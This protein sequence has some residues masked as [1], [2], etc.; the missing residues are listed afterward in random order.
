MATLDIRWIDDNSPNFQT[1]IKKATSTDGAVTWTDLGIIYDTGVAV[2]AGFTLGQPILDVEVGVPKQ[3]GYVIELATSGSSNPQYVYITGDTSPTPIAVDTTNKPTPPSAFGTQR[4]FWVD[5]SGNLWVVGLSPVTHNIVT[6]KSTDN[7][8]TWTLMDATHAPTV[9]NTGNW[10]WDV[11]N[12][13]KIQF[14]VAD[15]S[16]F[17]ALQEFD[18]ATGLYTSAHDS[19]TAL[20]TGWS[21][22]QVAVN[23]SVVAVQY[24]A[25]ASPF[26][27]SLAIFDVSWNNVGIISNDTFLCTMEIDSTGTSYSVHGHIDGSG[28]PVMTVSVYSVAGS[29]IGDAA[30]PTGSADG[31]LTGSP[32][33]AVQQPYVDAPNGNV[34]FP[35]K[36]FTTGGELNGATF[37]CPIGGASLS[38]PHPV[39]ATTLAEFYGGQVGSP[40]GVTATCRVPARVP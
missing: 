1:V 19:N 31:D 2:P 24:A 38:S 15:G 25:A 22:G 21:L 10:Y 37:L 13:T 30:F 28:N 7:G 32:T 26:K 14:I 23:Q 8:V 33:G 4:N 35:T 11:V 12:S 9:A 17:M 20:G 40:G 36:C 34:V 29:H 18:T 6:Y 39:Q 27:A 5:N 16:G 3:K